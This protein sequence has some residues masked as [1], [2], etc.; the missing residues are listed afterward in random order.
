MLE[1]SCVAPPDT[2]KQVL[3]LLY[4]EAYFIKVQQKQINK[5]DRRRQ[6][7]F[8]GSKKNKPSKEMFIVYAMMFRRDLYDWE[9]YF[10]YCSLDD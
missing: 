8:K 3:F 9:Q 7:R 2:I 5:D 4:T 1:E 10:L 6:T